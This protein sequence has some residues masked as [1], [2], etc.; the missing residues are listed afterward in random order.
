[1]KLID[2]LKVV[3]NDTFIFVSIAV[4]GMQFETRHS[5]E[6]YI[7]NGD[8]LNKRKIEQIYTDDEGLH[9]RLEN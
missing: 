7:T 5:A 1:M 9:V 6:F 3:D 2:F 8:D 4:C